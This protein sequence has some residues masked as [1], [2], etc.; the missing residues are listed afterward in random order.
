MADEDENQPIFGGA[1]PIP[2]GLVAALTADHDRAHMRAEERDARITRFLDSLD[3]D[4]LMALRSILNMG[5]PDTAFGLNQY[6]DG[7]AATLLRVVHHV[8][9]DTG[10]DPLAQL[11]ADSSGDGA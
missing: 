9:P 10:E 2:S 3:V 8:D 7:Q 6:Y 11:K 5:G 4:Q 1:L